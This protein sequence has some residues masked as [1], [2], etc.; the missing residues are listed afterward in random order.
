M[1]YNTEE[2][3]AVYIAI[4]NEREKLLKEYERQDAELE[5]DLKKVKAALLSTCNSVNADT[6]RTQSGTVM[7]KLNERFYCSDWDV[8]HK[9]LVEN[10]AVELLERRIHQG[11]F[12]QFLS[13][14]GADGLPPGVNVMREFDISVRKPTAS[15][16]SEAN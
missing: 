4:R 3:V 12:K 14:H 16:S 13:D 1:S 15:S 8:F 7:R 5:E 6:I 10:Q 11:N 9:F 2:M